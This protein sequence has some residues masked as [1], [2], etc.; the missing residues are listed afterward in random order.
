M[1]PLLV[2]IAVLKVAVAAAN[3]LA[4]VVA[5]RVAVPSVVVVVVELDPLLLQLVPTAITTKT[6]VV[7][8]TTLRRLFM[9]SSRERHA[10]AA[11]TSTR[12]T[13][14]DLGPRRCVG[15]APLVVAEKVTVPVGDAPVLPRAGF[16]ENSVST[17]IVTW[18]VWFAETDAGLPVMAEVVE[19]LV[20][21]R[22]GALVLLAMKLLSPLY[23]A[24]TLCVPTES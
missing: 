22:V 15:T 20:T 10:I 3:P 1:V 4:S 21:V 18:K 17:T 2:I 24:W 7:S 8:Q 19:A 23:A 11:K 14:L 16:E 5:M 12:I 6:A 13:G 9:P